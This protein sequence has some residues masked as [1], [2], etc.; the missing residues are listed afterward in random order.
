MNADFHSFSPFQE[1][2]STIEATTYRIPDYRTRLRRPFGLG[3][4][5][6]YVD[7]SAESTSGGRY[8]ADALGGKVS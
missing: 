5:R 8:Q 7:S 2:A 1:S 3:M 6:V 4:A